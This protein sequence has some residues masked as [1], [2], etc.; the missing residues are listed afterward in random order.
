VAA[1][2]V[3]PGE[4]NKKIQIIQ[5]EYTGKNKNGFPHPPEE[6]MV[7]Q[8][9]AKVSNTSGT[10][11]VKANSEF[12]EAKKRFLIRYTPKI[13]TDMVIRY[14]GKDHDIKYINPYGDG[15]EYMEIW[16]ELSERV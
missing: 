7:H 14:N 10:E 2:Y 5:M 6:R 12:S 4:L 15:R 9:F 11:I 16:A 1:M 13:N 3:N 8:C